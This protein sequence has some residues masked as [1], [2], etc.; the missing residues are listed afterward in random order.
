MVNGCL[1]GLLVWYG[2]V[3]AGLVV[4]DVLKARRRVWVGCDVMC[5]VG[6]SFWITI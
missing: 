4:V 3:M 6:H 2:I 5:D 1:V